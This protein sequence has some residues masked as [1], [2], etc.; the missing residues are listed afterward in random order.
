M[1]EIDKRNKFE[2][3][4][5]TY[6]ETKEGKVFIDWQGRTVTTLSGTQA[7]KFIAKIGRAGF[8]EAQLLMAKATGHFKHGNERLR[9]EEERMIP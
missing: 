5:F 1:G 7:A 9:R 8:K 2:E 3:E 6:R 4:V